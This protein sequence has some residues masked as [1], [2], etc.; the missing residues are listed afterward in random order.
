MES[1]IFKKKIACGI[2]NPG[3]WNPELHKRLQSTIQ[4]PLTKTRIQYLESGILLREMQNP[5]LSWIP[6]HTI[7]AQAKFL[8]KPGQEWSLR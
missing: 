2:R 3:L 1:K 5:I 8:Q 4:V 6:L 7:H